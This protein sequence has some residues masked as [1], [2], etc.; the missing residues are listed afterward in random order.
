MPL[1]EKETDGAIKILKACKRAENHKDLAP[2]EIDD[3]GSLLRKEKGI[4]I[5][6]IS[7]RAS[8]WKMNHNGK[9][10][11]VLYLNGKVYKGWD[12]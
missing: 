2:Q 6:R 10:I 3:I 9:E 7:R 8:V 11:V 12:D 5:K 1:T 4:K